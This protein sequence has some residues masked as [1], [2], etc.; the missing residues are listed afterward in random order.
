MMQ[1]A[2]SEVH[3]VLVVIRSTVICNMAPCEAW[4]RGLKQQSNFQLVG[5]AT[6]GWSVVCLICIG[7]YT[8][9]PDKS[10]L[11]SLLLVMVFGSLIMVTVI[12]I[13]ISEQCKRRNE[14]LEE[15]LCPCEA[16][17]RSTEKPYCFLP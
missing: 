4:L 8:A 11:P 7:C 12:R 13:L 9:S 14:H 16:T 10:S 5:M 1:H 15:Q 6:F 3:I 17:C 2:G